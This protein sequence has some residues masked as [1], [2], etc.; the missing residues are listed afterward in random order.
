MNGYLL[1]THV[2]IWWLSEPKRISTPARDAIRN[3]DSNLFVSAA[4]IWE[5][6][7]KRA[8]GRLEY[9][10]NL[11]DVLEDERVAVLSIDIRHALS[12]A[13]LPA[14]HRD[15]FDRMQ[16]VQAKLE[17]LTIITCDDKFKQYGVSTLVG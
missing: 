8:L 6:A 3:P 16:I 14:L 12:V 17:S 5:M 1:D 9:P 2:L 10:D 4:A 7:I 15:P 13:H 11:A